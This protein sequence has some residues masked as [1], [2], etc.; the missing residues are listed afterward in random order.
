MS[1]EKDYY[2]DWVKS[3]GLISYRT[4]DGPAH[5]ETVAT[6][7]KKAWDWLIQEV[8]KENATPQE[9][10]T[11]LEDENGMFF[12]DDEDVEPAPLAMKNRDAIWCWGFI[13]GG[14]MGTVV[15]VA[16]I[17]LAIRWEVLL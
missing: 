13:C 17:C 7:S 15:T 14:L 9:R 8:E 3:K 4:I 10:V 6:V 5:S 12:G 16:T 2:F 11:E 1:T